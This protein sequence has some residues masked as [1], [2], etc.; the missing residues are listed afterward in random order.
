MLLS[1][2][3]PPSIIS[4]ILVICSLIYLI[5]IRPAIEKKRDNAE[6][7]NRVIGFIDGLYLA[8]IA[9]KYRCTNSEIRNYVRAQ[10]E[11]AHKLPSNQFLIE[12]TTEK[13]RHYCSF[14]GKNDYQLFALLCVAEYGKFIGN[15]E[16]VSYCESMMLDAS[17]AGIHF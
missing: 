12:Y 17:R 14:T 5:F 15:D 1:A 11:K 8:G 13:G 10:L 6:F 16:L 4:G 7:D 9:W 3:S 2:D